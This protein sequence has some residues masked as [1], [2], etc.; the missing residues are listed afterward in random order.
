MTSSLRVFQVIVSVARAINQFC[1]KSDINSI[2]SGRLPESSNIEEFKE[3]LMKGMDMVTEDE[4]RWSA[5]IYPE[6]PT[7]CGKLKDLGS[8]DASFF[9]VPPK[10]ARVM[11][12]QLRIM[13]EVTYEALIDAGVNPS[14]LRG[15]RTGVFVGVSCSD[16]NNFWKRNTDGLYILKIFDQ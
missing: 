13:L 10:Q 14:T 5:N 16:A 6:M 9:K 2:F 8:F 4:R 7:R 1:Y 3:N 12:P 15:S 11:D